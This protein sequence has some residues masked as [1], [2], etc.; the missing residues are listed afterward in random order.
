MSDVE[1]PTDERPPIDELSLGHTA[2]VATEGE[3]AFVV[4]IRGHQVVEAFLDL[5]V[6]EALTAPNTLEIR[7]LP[8]GLKADLA[9]ALH[10]IPEHG[11]LVA[12]N[13]IRNRFAHDRHATLGEQESSQLQASWSEPVR[14]AFKGASPNL[15]F[16]VDVPLGVLR[17]T[18]IALAMILE[19][20][21]VAA[22]DADASARIFNEVLIDFADYR[23]E[24]SPSDVLHERLEADRAQR[25]ANGRL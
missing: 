22:R 19:R 2:T 12:I 8:F 10:G 17:F 14:E 15:S 4:S 16:P 7:R 20:A 18:L 9:C 24:G 3:D 5:L 6:I 13:R 23:A 1:P 21:L 11:T 25:N